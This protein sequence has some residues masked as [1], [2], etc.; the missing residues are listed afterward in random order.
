[1]GKSKGLV[2]LICEYNAALAEP[3]RV[4]MM[5]IMG[6]RPVNTVSVSDFAEILGISQ[7]TATKHLKIL[8]SVDL[9]SCK[10]VG[11]CVY[12]SLNLDAINQYHNLLELAFEKGFTPC[13]FGFKCENCPTADTC[14]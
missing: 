13:P 4:K 9:V 8:H 5:K 14:S 6:S 1:M 3:Q 10:R 11:S 2:N 12:Y 7:P